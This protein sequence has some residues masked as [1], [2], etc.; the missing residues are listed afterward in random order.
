MQSEIFF[1]EDMDAKDT[2]LTNDYNAKF[3]ACSFDISKFVGQ[4]I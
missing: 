3:K 1:D 2:L 4:S